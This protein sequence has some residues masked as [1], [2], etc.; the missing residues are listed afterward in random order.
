MNATNPGIIQMGDLMLYG[1]YT[2]V[3]FYEYFRTSYAYTRLGKI[4][5]PAA[6]AA[7]LESGDISISFQIE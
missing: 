6:L 2:L 3:L 7:A 1:S 4:D 5:H